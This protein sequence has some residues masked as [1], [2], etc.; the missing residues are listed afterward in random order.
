MFSKLNQPAPPS[1]PL[2]YNQCSKTRST[3]SSTRYSASHR[4]DFGLLSASSRPAKNRPSTR[5]NST[6]S[7]SSLAPVA[8]SRPVALPHL[9]GSPSPPSSLA[10]SASS[11][12]LTFWK[13]A[14]TMSSSASN[15]TSEMDRRESLKRNSSDV[16]WEYEMLIDPKRLDRVKCKL[17]GHEM[18]GGIHRLKQHVVGIKGQVAPCPK[19]SA[20]AKTKCKNALAESKVKKIQKSAHEEEVMQEVLILDGAEDEE[21]SQGTRRQP[22]TLGPMDKFA[23]RIDPDAT[24]S[25]HYILDYMF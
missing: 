17:C 3:R 7:R 21:A 8:L 23:N 10:Q 9:A 22:H 2:E 4:G 6:L 5:S 14:G 25:R 16:G 24:L 1:H 12:F 18:S 11:L 15:A 19:A 13:M 20:E